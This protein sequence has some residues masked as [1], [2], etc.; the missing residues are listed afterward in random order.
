MNIPRVLLPM[1]TH[2]GVGGSRQLEVTNLACTFAPH[3]T[4]FANTCSHFTTL[5]KNACIYKHM[6]LPTL[7]YSGTLMLPLPLMCIY[8]LTLAQCTLLH[9]HSTC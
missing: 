9:P 2:G 3:F 1:Q 8:L 5:L 7:A 4:T 6:H